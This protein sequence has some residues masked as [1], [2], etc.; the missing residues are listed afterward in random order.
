MH[1]QQHQLALHRLRPTTER[2]YPNRSG[3]E[4]E[5]FR[6]C[7]G[8]WDAF[9]IVQRAVAGGSMPRSAGGEIEGRLVAE[10]LAQCSVI[11]AG[12]AKWF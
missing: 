11:C 2:H 12:T 6:G 7:G 1:L 9:Y 5:G 4:G 8:R 3:G 10:A